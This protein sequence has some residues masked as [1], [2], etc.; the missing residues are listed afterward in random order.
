MAVHE[1]SH[2]AM[3]RVLG[4]GAGLISIRP[5]L[6]FGGVA[7]H[8]RIAVPKV[9]PGD[10]DGPVVLMRP[11][12]RRSLE[13][14][15]LITVA[16]KLGEYQL[17]P[18]ETG[19]AALPEADDEQALRLAEIVSLNRR[20]AASLVTAE[21][22]GVEESDAV[23]ARR[24][25]WALVGSGVAER[26]VL[27]LEA[28]ALELVLTDRFRRI[29]DALVPQVLQHRVLSARAVRAVLNDADKEAAT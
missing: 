12:L 20:E 17:L 11:A 24:R 9:L 15:I 7:K 21:R 1:A 4:V 3:A 25:A 14:Q 18:P 10:L 23:Y 8:G 22:D 13:K 2:A 27:M 26:Y 5:G 19:F 6:N 16:G 28:V 29:V